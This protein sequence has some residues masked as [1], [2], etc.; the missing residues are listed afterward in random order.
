[1]H[2]LLIGLFL[3]LS[4]SYAVAQNQNKEK[5]EWKPKPP[6][7]ASIPEFASWVVNVRRVKDGE[8]LPGNTR[9]NQLQKIDSVKTKFLKRDRLTYRNGNVV[10]VWYYKNLVVIISPNGDV[11]LDGTGSLANRFLVNRYS[12]VGYPML[13]WVSL[14]YFKEG[15]ELKSGRMA[16]LYQGLVPVGR[17]N[18]DED[19]ESQAPRF[20]AQGNAKASKTKE[21]STSSYEI[22]H[23]ALIDDQTKRPIIVQVGSIQMKYTF[24]TPPTKMLRMPKVAVDELKR[25]NEQQNALKR[26]R[27]ISRK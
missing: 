26:L 12:S 22:E 25:V 11:S 23:M 3:L 10:E 7:V 18:S 17:S 24:R 6:F 8:D 21:E 27:A 1:M 9:G 5:E 14:R 2:R 16:A 4:G 13:D 15:E 19:P 20:D